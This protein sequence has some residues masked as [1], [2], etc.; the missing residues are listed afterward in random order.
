[1]GKGGNVD[2]SVQQKVTD[3]FDQVREAVPR[4]WRNLGL[5][6]VGVLFNRSKKKQQP[7][8]FDYTKAVADRLR[9]KVRLRWWHCN[10]QLVTSTTIQAWVSLK[11][12]VP[13]LLTSM[14]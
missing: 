10:L 3:A 9:P 8:P 1:M 11:L 6:G 2:E 12:G 4:S 14:S 13:S 5:E 7:D